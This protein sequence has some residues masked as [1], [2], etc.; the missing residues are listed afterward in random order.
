LYGEDSNG[1]SSGFQQK[2][3]YG[4]FEEYVSGLFEKV[5]SE[6]LS[7]QKA[8]KRESSP[9]ST[10]HSRGNFSSSPTEIAEKF[11]GS[12]GGSEGDGQR[13]AQHEN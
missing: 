1:S 4:S 9:H 12:P 8:D 13:L 6:G 3:A 7:T 11:G 10:S 2:V 5:L